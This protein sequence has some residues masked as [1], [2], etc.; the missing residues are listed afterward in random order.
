MRILCQ[1]LFVNEEKSKMALYLSLA[2]KHCQH[3]KKLQKAKVVEV[4]SGSGQYT[5][6]LRISGLDALAVD[7]K[8]NRHTTQTETIDLDLTKAEDQEKVRQILFA[9]TVRYI[10]FGPPCGT[11]SR[12]RERP[13]PNHPDPPKPL[14]SEAKPYGLDNIEKVSDKKRVESANKLHEID[15]YTVAWDDVSGA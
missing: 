7:W 10:H 14:R 13:L 2:L 3:K 11:F 8:G 4:F 1:G 15:P 5:C 12:A 9:P 6:K